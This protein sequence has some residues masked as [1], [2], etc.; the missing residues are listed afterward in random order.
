VPN[1]EITFNFSG[2]IVIVTGAARGIGAALA[3]GFA[4]SGARVVAIDLDVADL[5][6]VTAVAD[7]RIIAKAADV[8][9]SASIDQ[10]VDEVVEQFGRID[11]LVNNAGILRDGVAWKLSDQDWDAVVNV[12]LGGTFK[13]TRACVP[14]FRDAGYGRIINVTS[15]SGIRGS[16]GQSNYAAAKAGIVGLTKTAAKELARF[17]VTANAISPAAQTRMTAG[18]DGERMDALMA[19]SPTGRFAEPDEIFPAV[20]FLASE[21]ASFITGVVLP[22]DGGLLM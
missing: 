2:R 5:A 3:K 8:C 19:T 22:V 20:A 14:H 17:G 12:H 6:D 21:Q 4:A 11:I 15:Y 10:V 16:F 7:G 13:C 18:I 9:D 1:P